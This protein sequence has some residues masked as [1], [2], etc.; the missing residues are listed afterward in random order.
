MRQVFTLYINDNL[1]YSQPIQ[2]SSH[3]LFIIYIICIV[4]FTRKAFPFSNGSYIINLCS[5]PFCPFCAEWLP[6]SVLFLSYASCIIDRKFN[7]TTQQTSFRETGSSKGHSF[8]LIW[9]MWRLVRLK[10]TRRWLYI[11][12]NI[13]FHVY[14]AFSLFS[15]GCIYVCTYKRFRSRNIWLLSH[16]TPLWM[17]V[18]A[19]F[20][21]R[22]FPTFIIGNRL[23]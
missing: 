5:C 11:T 19:N 4:N 9:R 17:N 23:L 3:H 18:N 2:I 20:T 10:S 15:H 1:F 22:N 21:S 7:T 12:W 14:R 6:Y 16:L 13:V 8:I